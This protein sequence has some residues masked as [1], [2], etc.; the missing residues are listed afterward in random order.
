[1][2]SQLVRGT[3][4]LGQQLSLRGFSQSSVYSTVADQ[5]PVD[6]RG[7][8][9]VGLHW[10]RP[11]YRL[12]CPLHRACCGAQGGRQG[13]QVGPPNHSSW[14]TCSCLLSSTGKLWLLDVHCSHQA[15]G[16]LPG[17]ATVKGN[18]PHPDCLSWKR[19]RL[20]APAQVQAGEGK[21]HALS[22]WFFLPWL[23]AGFLVLDTQCL[24]VARKVGCIHCAATR[25]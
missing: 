20:W 22:S 7:G 17:R 1:M 8:A 16:R 2:Q 3:G 13:S 23:P 24:P 9:E 4:S 6:C 10:R 12:I 11:C 5:D 18:S 19:L 21:C 25:W 14:R 15:L